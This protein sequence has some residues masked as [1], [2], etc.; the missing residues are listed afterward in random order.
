MR[1]TVLGTVDSNSSQA[2]VAWEES[3]GE[4]LI[5]NH[6]ASVVLIEVALR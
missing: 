1:D 5:P 3:E 4:V 6:V 2:E